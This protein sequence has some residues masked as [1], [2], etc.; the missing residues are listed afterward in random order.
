MYFI[1]KTL[2]DGIVPQGGRDPPIEEYCAIEIPEV[3]REIGYYSTTVYIP[4]ES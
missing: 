1:C 2:L 4:P 3:C